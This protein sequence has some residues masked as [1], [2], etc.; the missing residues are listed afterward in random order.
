M[1]NICR[2]FRSS[3]ST[4]QEQVK[5]AIIRISCAKKT[6]LMASTRQAMTAVAILILCLP[7]SLGYNYGGGIECKYLGSNRCQKNHDCLGICAR[8]GYEDTATL[9]IPDPRVFGPQQ[10]GVLVCCCLI[11]DP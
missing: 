7:L 3:L 11:Y 1:E 6:W 8:D 10:Q 5:H 9:C 2:T 4:F